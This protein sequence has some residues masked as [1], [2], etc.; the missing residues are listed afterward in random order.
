M[1][2]VSHFSRSLWTECKHN[3]SLVEWIILLYF[4]GKWFLFHKCVV[5][6]LLLG[7]FISFL[8]CGQ[9][10]T[11][12]TL[13]CADFIVFFLIQSHSFPSILSRAALCLRN[14]EA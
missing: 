11:F 8:V 9:E 12:L 7:G 3:T 5:H 4:S 2:R 1:F 13:V 6:H 10:V 14:Y